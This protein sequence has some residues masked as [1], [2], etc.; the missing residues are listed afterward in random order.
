MMA[1]GLVD[2]IFPFEC[3][4]LCQTVHAGNSIQQ[5]TDM[6]SYILVAFS[7]VGCRRLL[8]KRTFL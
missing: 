1:L 2:K 5:I 7:R 6:H 8:Q 3:V 4:L